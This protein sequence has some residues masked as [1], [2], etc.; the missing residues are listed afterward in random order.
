[1]AGFL[2]RRY[3]I[4]DGYAEQVEELVL[5]PVT[6]ERWPYY[7]IIFRMAA[8]KGLGSLKKLPGEVAEWLKAPV[9]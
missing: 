9:C 2:L 8:T 1:M 4:T 6:L 3:L 5:L 7:A